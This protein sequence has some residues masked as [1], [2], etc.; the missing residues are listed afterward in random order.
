MYRVKN[1]A[2][3]TTNVIYNMGTTFLFLEII[4]ITGFI[5]LI[6]MPVKINM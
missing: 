1:L 4:I 6:T 3:D 2:Y 5:S